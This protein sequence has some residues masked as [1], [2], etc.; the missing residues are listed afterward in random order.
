MFEIFYI[1][2]VP[3]LQPT[4]GKIKYGVKKKK[5]KK[6]KNRIHIGCGD[7]SFLRSNTYTGT[8]TK[9]LW[10]EFSCSGICTL[11][12]CE[13]GIQ[14]RKPFPI[15]H[16]KYVITVCWELFPTIY[17]FPVTKNMPWPG[18]LFPVEI[19]H[20]IFSNLNL[21]TVQKNHPGWE[22]F[23]SWKLWKLP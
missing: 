5:K 12:C 15:A 4:T 8:K 18:K 22:T 21:F 1:L 19:F 7:L 16:W 20:S 17:P 3:I 6:K 14:K 11:F 13:F 23:P 2:M 10:E 9:K